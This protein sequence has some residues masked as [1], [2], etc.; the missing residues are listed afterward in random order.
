MVTHAHGPK[1]VAVYSRECGCFKEVLYII[2]DFATWKLEQWFNSVIRRCLPYTVGTT[3]VHVCRFKTCIY[4]IFLYKPKLNSSL[5]H[6]YAG[7]ETESSAGVCFW[8]HLWD[9]YY[10]RS[11]CCRGAILHRKDWIIHTTMD[12]NTQTWQTADCCT[13]HIIIIYHIIAI[14]FM[15]T[16]IIGIKIL[17]AIFA[18]RRSLP[19][20]MG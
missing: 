11:D 19:S 3:C 7:R 16:I 15:I 10:C 12:I 14:P 1:P 8:H 18:H 4:Y 5:Y 2:W 20:L 17:I 6:M 9:P 13:S